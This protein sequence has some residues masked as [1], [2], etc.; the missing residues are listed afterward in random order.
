MALAGGGVGGE[1]SCLFARLF[2]WPTDG[3]LLSTGGMVSAG[4]GTRS[5]PHPRDWHI[6]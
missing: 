5:D 4:I 6:G 2:C 1:G 3:Q